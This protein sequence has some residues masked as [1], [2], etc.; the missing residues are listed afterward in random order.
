MLDMGQMSPSKVQSYDKRLSPKMRRWAEPEEKSRLANGLA[1]M[2]HMIYFGSRVFQ[3][4][5]VKIF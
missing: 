1:N 3:I 5:S 4:H 2:I